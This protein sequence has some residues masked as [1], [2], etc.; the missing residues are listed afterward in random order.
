MFGGGG[1]GSKK[2]LSCQRYH[3][4]N[5]NKF[6]ISEMTKKRFAGIKDFP[7]KT[8]DFSPVPLTEIFLKIFSSYAFT[9]TFEPVNTNKKR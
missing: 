6:S 7:R 9:P 4:R 1:G 5:S 8:K 3:F 2:K